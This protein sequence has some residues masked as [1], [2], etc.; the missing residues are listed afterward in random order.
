MTRTFLLL[1]LLICC[2]ACTPQSQ[3]VASQRLVQKSPIELVYQPARMTTES[4]LAV[5]V[6]APVHWQLIS[7][8]MI[9]LSMDMPVMPLFFTKAAETTGDVARWQSQF[10][11]GACADEQMTWRLE[12]LFKDETGAEQRLSDDFLV[13]RR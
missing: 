13:Y 1:I 9:G 3:A 2:N 10:L 7:A 11:V 4:P 8:R 5:D 6:N 12:L